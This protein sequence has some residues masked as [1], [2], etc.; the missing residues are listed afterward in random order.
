MI[1]LANKAGNTT[2]NDSIK[3]AFDPFGKPTSGE[4]RKS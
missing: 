2:K 4:R 3:V 1:I